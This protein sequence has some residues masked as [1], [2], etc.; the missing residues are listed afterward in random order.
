[1]IPRPALE[2]GDPSEEVDARRK[3]AAA[4][5]ERLLASNPEPARQMLAH[6]LEWH[7]R[8]EKA[9][10]WE[11]FRLRQLSDEELLEE[12]DGLA[13]LK[14][15]QRV[16]GTLACPIDRYQFP[17]QDT[18]I[19]VGDSVE[20]SM[21]KF[22]SVEAIDNTARTIDI[23]KRRDTAGVHPTSIFSHEIYTGAE[24]AESLYRIGAWVAANGIDAPGRY[25]A[26]RDLLLRRPPNVNLAG[27]GANVVEES[28]R[29][30]LQLDRGILP[31]QGRLAQEK[32]TQR[33][34]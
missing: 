4:L 27:V 11:Y 23:K 26:G 17:P 20:T 24:Q 9:P 1:V 3:R 12:R 18:Q 8:E 5:T 19:R 7:R 32:P 15:A 31:I 33:P 34:G 28:R 2:P 14:F 6:M 16:G 22:G 29:L 21:G 13:G 30:V 25:R 10:W